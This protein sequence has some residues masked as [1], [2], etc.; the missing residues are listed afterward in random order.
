MVN[1]SLCGLALVRS[2]D[3]VAV[4]LCRDESLAR[5]SS[6]GAAACWAGTAAAGTTM[7]ARRE[8]G[9]D[10]EL[11]PVR[12]IGP[13]EDQ[14]GRLDLAA[15]VPPV[16]EPHARLAARGPR[17]RSPGP[18]DCAPRTA[19]TA[20]ARRASDWPAVVRPRTDEP[21][22]L[23]GVVVGLPEDSAVG[24]RVGVAAQEQRLAGPRPVGLRKAQFRDVISQGRSGPGAQPG[25]A[26][27]RTIARSEVSVQ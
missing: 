6:N 20:V 24:Q 9:P 23:G 17:G 25:Q 16:P 14:V 10:R 7:P 3:A 13:V 12:V 5:A 11:R 26:P 18:C 27:T 4:R 22:D 2:R 19:P 21:V 1:S 15:A 8:V